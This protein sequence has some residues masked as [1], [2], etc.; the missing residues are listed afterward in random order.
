M[1]QIRAEPSDVSAKSRANVYILGG[2]QAEPTVGY[3]SL[4]VLAC[5]T[6]ILAMCV[7]GSERRTSASQGLWDKVYIRN[8]YQKTRKWLKETGRQKE[9]ESK[10]LEHIYVFR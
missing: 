5:Y 9:S 6:G 8:S 1:R 4:L 3:G 10:Q 2:Y 7:I